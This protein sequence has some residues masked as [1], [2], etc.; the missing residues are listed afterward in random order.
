M[1]RSCLGTNHVGP[2]EGAGEAGSDDDSGDGAGGGRRDVFNGIVVV[3]EVESVFV[4]DARRGGGAKEREV[5]A[6]IVAVADHDSDFLPRVAGGGEGGH[7]TD[8]GAVAPDEPGLEVELVG[9]SPDVGTGAGDGPDAGGEVG[10]AHE[11]GRTDVLILKAVG[12]CGGDGK[13]IDG[14]STK[15]VRVV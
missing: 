6:G 7:A 2:L 8:D 13:V 9:C 15:G 4:I 3:V 5:G 14:S 1:G 10:A 12:G 11:G